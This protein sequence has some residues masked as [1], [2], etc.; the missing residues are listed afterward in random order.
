MPPVR[1]RF[2]LV[3]ALVVAAGSLVRA[4]SLTAQISGNVLDLT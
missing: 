4:Q 2:A 1:L 3:L